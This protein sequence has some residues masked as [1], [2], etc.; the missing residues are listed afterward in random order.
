MFACLYFFGRGFLLLGHP[1]D[2]RYFGVPIKNRHSKHDAESEFMCFV[3]HLRNHV[4]QKAPLLGMVLK[5]FN[6][7]A[8]ILDLREPEPSTVL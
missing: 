4:C 2:N 6:F 5:P 1:K 7:Q 8:R 3:V